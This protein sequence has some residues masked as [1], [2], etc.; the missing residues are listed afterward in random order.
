MV[1]FG[2]SKNKANKIQ[3]KQRKVRFFDIVDRNKLNF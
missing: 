3:I 2:R 1:F